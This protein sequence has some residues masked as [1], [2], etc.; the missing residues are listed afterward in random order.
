MRFQEII[1]GVVILVLLNVMIAGCT[2]TT[3]EKPQ[4]VTPTPTP[5]LPAVDL[6]MKGYVAHINGNFS[7][8][9]DLYDQAIAADPKYT[10]AW[11]DKGNVLIRLNRTEEAISAFNSALTLENN[12]PE[13]WNSRGEALMTMG[14]Y[15][16]ALDSFDNALKYAPEYVKAQENRKL[17]LEKL[18]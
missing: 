4:V 17:A 2:S 3:S 14:K 6:H 1:S 12:L 9:L 8:A 10:R 7:T 18:K 16:E 11:I 5:V 15:S 13:I